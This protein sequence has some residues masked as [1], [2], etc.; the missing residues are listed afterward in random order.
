MRQEKGLWYGVY[1]SLASVK[2]TVFIFLILAAFSLVGTLMPQGLSEGELLRH[3]GPGVAS[4][5]QAFGLN[6]V[7]H[8]AWFRLLVLLLCVNLVIC[9]IER[10]PK[11]L[12]LL[13]RREE[14]ISPNNLLQ[15]ACNSRITTRLPWQET[16]SRLTRIIS[17]EFAPVTPVE[18]PDAFSGFAE[19]GRWSPLMVYVVHSSVLLILVGALMGSFWGFKGFMNIPEGEASSEV[20]LYTGRQSI[21]LPFQIRCDDFEASFYDTGAP[22]EYRSDLTILT[23]GQE[24]LKQSIRVN[25][26]LTYAGISFYQSSYGTTLRQAEVELTDKGT[27]KSYKLTLPY[28]VDVPIP[29]TKDRVRAVDYQQ[30]LSRFGPAVAVM[31]MKEGEQEP[32]G[33]WILVNMPEFHGNR[34][35]SYKVQV[36]RTETAQYTGLQVKRDPGVWIVYLGFIVMVLGVAMTYYSCHRKIWFHATPGKATTQIVVAGRAGKNSLAFENDFKRLSDRLHAE[37]K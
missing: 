8:T 12:K 18:G 2:L 29:G 28:R 23:Q 15:F 30:D 22:K 37:M 6:D 31:L 19:K 14:G 11:T 4:W 10:L 3:F 25:D 24:V 34:I 21:V 26:P 35:G 33:S 16:Q 27:G 5:I 36:T 20:D 32:G 13:Q 1:N 17:E 9:S 7:Y